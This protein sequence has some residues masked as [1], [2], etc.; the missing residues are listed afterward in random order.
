MSAADSS[1]HEDDFV[2]RVWAWL[3]EVEDPEIPVVSIVDLGMVRDVRL[4]HGRVRVA[5]A[6]TYGGC[7]ATSFIER[8]VRERLA[9]EGHA[10]A[11]I[12]IV[13][14]PAWTTDWISE[15]GRARLLACG[16]APPEPVAQA[17]ASVACPR[18][19]SA[20]TDRITEFGSTPCKALY[21]CTACMEPFERFK[22]L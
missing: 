19:G 11:V 4:E 18:C 22:C 16:I 17:S 10:D 1:N 13:L 7:P 5:L 9:R 21:R 3:A 14:A 12:D 20:A 8:A 6:P 15:Q 2:A